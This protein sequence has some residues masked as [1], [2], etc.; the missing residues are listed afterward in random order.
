MSGPQCVHWD[1]LGMGLSDRGR[2]AF[3]CKLGTRHRPKALLPP[4][5]GP[6][7]NLTNTITSDH[8][9]ASVGDHITLFYTIVDAIGPKFFVHIAS[10]VFTDCIS[11][12]YNS[13]FHR[14]NV[15]GMQKRKGVVLEC[16]R[17]MCMIF[18]L[19]HINQSKS[20]KHIT[21]RRLGPFD[22]QD[23]LW[24]KTHTWVCH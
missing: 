3:K 4:Y 8:E 17:C 7:P 23:V 2:Y 22:V 14:P 5:T 19:S 6:L 15:I 9:K 11:K 24:H 12:S 18:P 16:L 13:L 21:G 20:L 1:R 10:D